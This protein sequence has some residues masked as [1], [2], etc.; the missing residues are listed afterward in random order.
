MGG[1][2]AVVRSDDRDAVEGGPMGVRAVE[3]ETAGTSWVVNEGAV[4][5][6]PA[7]GSWRVARF[8]LFLV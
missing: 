2:A 1:A 6:V 8:L 5:G 3:A 7:G 4:T